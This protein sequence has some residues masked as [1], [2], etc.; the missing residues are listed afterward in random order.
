MAQS[1]PT[2][3]MA[4]AQDHQGCYWNKGGEGILCSMLSFR[5]ILVT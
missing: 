1:V 4:R 3:L 5:E 2:L